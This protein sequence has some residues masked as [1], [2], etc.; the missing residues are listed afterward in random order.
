MN[1]K[2]LLFSI[3]IPKKNIFSKSKFKN[4]YLVT[5]RC[6]PD[7]LYIVQMSKKEF[8]K[9]ARDDTSDSILKHAGIRLNHRR[10]QTQSSCDDFS[11][12][13]GCTLCIPVDTTKSQIDVIAICLF[14]KTRLDLPRFNFD[15][16]VSI[17]T[18]THTHIVFEYCY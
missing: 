7:Q 2:A 14:S 13:A 6:F 10:Q 16:P 1:F 8:L 5:N 18:D 12:R 11:I 3:Y 15:Q 9:K 17:F 4:E